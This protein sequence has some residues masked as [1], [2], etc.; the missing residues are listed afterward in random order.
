M[1]N[2]L[3]VFSKGMGSFLSASVLAFDASPELTGRR[4]TCARGGCPCLS[5]P[6]CLLLAGLSAGVQAQSNISL[7]ASSSSGAES[8]S[9]EMTAPS[10]PVAAAIGFNGASAARAP[11]P[12]AKPARIARWIRRTASA[13]MLRIRTGIS[14]SWLV[15][16]TSRIRL[17]FG[18]LAMRSGFR[19]TPLHH[20][21]RGRCPVL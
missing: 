4:R 5:V 17:Y 2:K 12:I 19:E 14:G 18:K 1:P 21:I 3:T 20:R 6:L 10:S 16:G 13:G 11:Q 8:E 15:E 7:T 9:V